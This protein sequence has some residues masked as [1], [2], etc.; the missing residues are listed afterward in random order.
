[1]KIQSVIGKKNK[2]TNKKT[3]GNAYI[4]ITRRENFNYI[5]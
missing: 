3:Y 4:S 2:Q 1:M 5:W